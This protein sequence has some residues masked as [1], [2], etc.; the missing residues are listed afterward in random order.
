[1][2]VEVRAVTR[3]FR[4]RGRTRVALR[5]VSL[6]VAA[7]QSLA[8][9]GESGSG[10]STLARLVAGLDRPTSGE[11]L[12]EGS[13]PRLG[14]GRRSPVQMVFQSPREA[15]NPFRSVGNSV[16]EPLRGI[17]RA[18]R[19]RRVAE[20]LERVGIDP[21][22]AD[23]RP[24]SFSGGQQQ[25]VVIARAL[26]AEPR[27]LVCDEPTSALDVSVQAQIVNLLLRVQGELGFALLLVTHDLGVVR[28][29]ADDVAVLREGELIEYGPAGR[30]FA[31]P[32]HEHARALLAAAA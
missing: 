22:Q 30:F 15:L 1:M 29:L 7:G 17:P 14:G 26:A 2:S 16:G 28:V 8:V 11:V 12:V 20:S 6:E 10:K 5:D 31:A 32:E 25:R 23:R 9:V 4:A 27:V 18:E 21:A 13:P 19:R 3:E 24:A